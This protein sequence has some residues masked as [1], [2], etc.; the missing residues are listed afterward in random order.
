MTSVERR[1]SPRAR[2]L[3][4]QPRRSRAP[5]SHTV[6]SG[7]V[8]PR[9]SR[10]VPNIGLC[11]CPAI[12]RLHALQA[13]WLDTR[14]SRGARDAASPARR[15]S[16][17]TRAAADPAVRIVTGH[18]PPSRGRSPAKSLRCCSG[19]SSA[20]ARA[21]L[22]FVV[23]GQD[24]ARASRGSGWSSKNM[25]SVR[26]SPMPSAPNFQRG[27]RVLVGVVGVGADAQHAHA[28]RTH[29]DAARNRPAKTGD[30]GL[31]FLPRLEQARQHLGGLGRDLA[32]RRPRRSSRP[33]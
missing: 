7:C 20:S 5:A 17:G 2:R 3:R 4:R 33:G 30:H 19:S 6:I 13:H 21:T 25:C 23:V 22:G 29:A 11:S 28:G 12:R 16:A 31:R 27:R 8:M 18:G 14:P 9:R 32:V 10:G 24:H 15:R 26:Q 1:R